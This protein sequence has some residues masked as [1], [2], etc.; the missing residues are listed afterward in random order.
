MSLCNAF[1]KTSQSLLVWGHCEQSES[2]TFCLER[3]AVEL[4]FL[5]LYYYH[6]GTINQPARHINQASH[7]FHKILQ[8]YFSAFL[9]LLEILKVIALSLA[10]SHIYK[11]SGSFDLH[12]GLLPGAF[13]HFLKLL[14]ICTV[15][16]SSI[17]L[18][19]PAPFPS[20]AWCHPGTE[21]FKKYIF[22]FCWPE[23]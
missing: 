23:F 6:N 14:C 11:G 21:D 16:P 18:C 8:L 5:L 3:W 4:H 1:E 15:K 12:R 7:K 13:Y 2:S 9:L 10:S 17:K 22:D 20:T 19:H